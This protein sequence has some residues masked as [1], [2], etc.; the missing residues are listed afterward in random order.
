MKCDVVIIGAG[1][2]GLKAAEILVKVDEKIEEGEYNLMV[3]YQKN[4]QKT[5]KSTTQ[6]IYVKN[7][8]EEKFFNQTLSLSKL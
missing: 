1:P 3:K 2:G 8:V 6:K 4:D 5:V 7:L